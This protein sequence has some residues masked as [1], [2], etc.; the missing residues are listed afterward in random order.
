MKKFYNQRVLYNE[1]NYMNLD[2]NDT[3]LACSKLNGSAL[4][5]FIYLCGK[6]S[7]TEYPYS[8]ASFCETCN[9]SKNGEK[10]AFFELVAEGYIT[11][12]NDDHYVFAP[13]KN[14]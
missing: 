1:K 6:E 5:L 11:K 4:K 8:P 9:V 13:I 2:I 10:D 12:I 7:Y 3:L 14:W